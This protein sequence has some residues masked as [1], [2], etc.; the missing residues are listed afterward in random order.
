[1]TVRTPVL[2]LKNINKS[3]SGVQVLH[4]I[5]FE[6]Y[7]GEIH[8]LVGENGAG[9]STLIK[10]ISGAY[11]ADSGALTYQGQTVH[12]LNPRWSLDHGIST[13]YQEIDTVPALSV[14]ENIALGN[15]PLGWGGN[16]DWSA[17]RLRAKK[18]LDEMGADIDLNVPVGR[19]KVAHQQMVVIARALSLNRRVLILDEP[20]AVFTASEIEILFRIIRRLKS[21][22]IAIIY[23][24]HHLDEIFQIGDRITVLRD[25]W[26]TR[27]GAVNE[28]DKNTLVQ[29]MVG[30]QIDLSQ[31]HGSSTPGA[32]LLRVVNL[33]RKG[34]F[35]KINFVLRQKEIVGVAGLV[36][37][38]RTEV[39]RALIGADPVDSGDVYLRGQKQS[40]RSPR[41]A[42]ALGMGMLPESRKE[43]GLVQV[44]SVTENAAY[45]AVEAGAR[46][47]VVPWKR[48]KKLVWQIIADLEVHYPSLNAEVQYLSGGNQQKV[49]LAKWLAAHC[50]VMILDE[51]TRGVD[52]GARSEIY[53]LMQRLKQDGKAILMISSDLPEILTQADRILVMA[54]GRIVGDLS[55]EGATEERILSLALQVGKEEPDAK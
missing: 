21:Q 46:L 5:S 38:G 26:V 19:L 27:T 49:V 31:R 15:E 24:S 43:E 55:H 29:A 51:P 45:S 42:L 32:E 40:I 10:I 33:T 47:G 41:K 28:F 16:I 2:Q 9:K 4:D 39:A 36:G 14:A 53:K 3:F 1:V 20:T 54:K 12:D 8:C 35:E 22:G 44:R 6:L 18:V 13:I 52:V 23:I 7:E 37:S 17:M 50:E 25:G 30:R 34:V 11:R 48:I